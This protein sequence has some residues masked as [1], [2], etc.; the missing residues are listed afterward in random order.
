MST[1]DTNR[2]YV[3]QGQTLQNICDAVKSKTSASTVNVSDIAT[4]IQ[5]IETGGSSAT[6]NHYTTSTSVLDGD[7]P[8]QSSWAHNLNSDELIY[9]GTDEIVVWNATA[10][11]KDEDDNSYNCVLSTSQP[12]HGYPEVYFSGMANE[13]E[14]NK[15]YYP[16]ILR[17][18]IEYIMHS[19]YEPGYYILRYSNGR[20]SAD[21]WENP[22]EDVF[23]KYVD[24]TSITFDIYKITL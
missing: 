14:G 1:I 17:Y 13:S 4:E 21:Y 10:T 8:L 22:P 9:S 24:V 5:N 12:A 20:I 11:V 3:I 7:I 18:S 15:F 16:V 2:S 6:I 19:V 23:L